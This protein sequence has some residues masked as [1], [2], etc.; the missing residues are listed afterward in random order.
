[1]LI[2]FA[3]ISA[4][5]A[6]LCI[7]FLLRAS[8]YQE[9]TWHFAVGIAIFVIAGAGSGIAAGFLHATT[10]ESERSYEVIKT[11]QLASLA[12]ASEVEGS[13]GFIYH[14]VGEKNVYRYVEAHEDGTF[15]F[16]E[17][18]A[19]RVPIREDA[20]TDTAR[21]EKISCTFKSTELATLLGNCGGSTTIH[22]PKGSVTSD[23]EID[24]SR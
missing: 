24:P 7:M 8:S 17:M 16:E 20:T 23:F 10:P 5:M 22:V 2:L 9:K 19:D 13:G 12:N 1:M 21:I 11:T 6:L 3:I 18:D 4:L 15:T 14:R